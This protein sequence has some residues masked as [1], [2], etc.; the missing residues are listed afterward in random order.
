MLSPADFGLYSLGGMD[1][2]HYAFWL[3][4][5][6]PAELERRAQAEAER[7][8]TAAGDACTVAPTSEPPS[9]PP[10]RRSQVALTLWE[11]LYAVCRCR[12]PAQ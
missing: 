2:A 8:A 3:A 11:R 1:S 4:G 10:D 6:D 5:V 9:E 12:V 7:A